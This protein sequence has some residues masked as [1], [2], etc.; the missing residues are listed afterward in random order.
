MTP[1]FCELLQNIDVDRLLYDCQRKSALDRE[2]LHDQLF[3]VLTKM[4]EKEDTF[5]HAFPDERSLYRYLSKATIQNTIKLHQRQNRRKELAKTNVAS[6][7]ESPEE[8][9]QAS[10]DSQDLQAIAQRH[11]RESNEREKVVDECMHLLKTIL[12]D[13]ESYIL[14][15]AKGQ[16]AGSLVFQYSHLAEALGWNRPKLYNRLERIRSIFSHLLEE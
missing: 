1:S 14:K 5:R 12:E 11:F 10:L 13:P 4:L 16:K 2:K 6:F 9:W 15:R 8:Q 3:E 7:T